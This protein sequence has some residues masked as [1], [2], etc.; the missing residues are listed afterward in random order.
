ML[1]LKINGA[2]VYIRK[3]TGTLENYNNT[4]IYN[5]ISKAAERCIYPLTDDQSHMIIL[6][7]EENLMDLSNND[8]PVQLVHTF[9]ENA[10]KQIRP[11]VAEAYISYRNVRKSWANMLQ[12]IMTKVNSLLFI[13]DKS[14]SNADS[15]LASTIGSL[16]TGYLGTSLTEE[17]FLYSDE[18]QALKDG[19]IYVHDKDKR[20]WYPLNCCLFDVSNVLSGGFEMSNIWYNEPK[21]IDV[22]F[23]VIGDITLMAASQQYGGFTISEIDKILEPYAI[24]SFENYKQD[25]LSLGI[26]E[27]KAT[28]QA[29]EKT[30]RDIYQ[31]FQGWEYKFNTVASSRGA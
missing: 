18:R 23:D 5:A 9:V 21:S 26:T 29:I 20:Y 1:T 19:F 8:V 16:I 7:V 12:S 15:K 10:L 11:D 22:A 27:E 4:K 24:K 25:Y 6:M 17:N 14:N 2:P 28:T 31:G 3:K 30:T 13:G